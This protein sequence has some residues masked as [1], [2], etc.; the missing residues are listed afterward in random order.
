MTFGTPPARRPSSPSVAPALIAVGEEARVSR[1]GPLA[2][3]GG[4]GW[5]PFA[6]AAAATRR[7]RSSTFGSTGGSGEEEARGAGHACPLTL[8]PTA[9]ASWPQPALDLRTGTERPAGARTAA[10][11]SRCARVGRPPDVARALRGPQREAVSSDR[12]RWPSTA[13][14]HHA[15]R[16]Q[17]RWRVRSRGFAVAGTPGVA[18][19]AASHSSTTSR[20]HRPARSCARSASA[21]ADGERRNA[22]PMLPRSATGRSSSGTA[23]L[24]SC[25]VSEWP[26]QRRSHT[27]SR[28]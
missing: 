13:A 5:R 27:R 2:C 15:G 7:S 6:S 11:R 9:S 16:R 28:P 20:R 26:G 23:G 3:P 10:V 8:A 25:A 19:A 14:A 1:R 24:A 22:P 18:C 4:A 21:G 12:R 17:S